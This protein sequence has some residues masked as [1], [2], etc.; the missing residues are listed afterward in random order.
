MD[1]LTNPL[2]KRE[3]RDGSSPHRGQGRRNGHGFVKPAQI[4]AV[5]LPGLVK[6]CSHPHKQEAFEK[7]V[8]ESVG[9][10]TIDGEVGPYS[11]SRHH[12]TDLIDHGV[13]QDPAEI[14]LDD[15]IEDGECCHHRPDV[16]QQSRCPGNAT[17]RAYTATFVVKA[18]KNTVPVGVPSG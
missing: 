3:G 7:H 2:N 15:G 17:A 12:E 14:V 4:R 9:H 6:D 11:D 10:S 8:V 16:D 1:L 18:L 13:P 5:D